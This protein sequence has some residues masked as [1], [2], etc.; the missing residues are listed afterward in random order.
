MRYRC[1]ECGGVVET[2]RVV[3][4]NAR[5]TILDGC[6]GVLHACL[7]VRAASA[8]KTFRR[9]NIESA[10]LLVAGLI[11]QVLKHEKQADEL[12]LPEVS[13]DAHETAVV[14]GQVV[15]ELRAAAEKVK[16]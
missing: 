2:D 1:S 8:K 5:C 15:A 12:G 4:M 7:K 6:T 16:S 11:P 14:L 10:C 3:G 13:L 9:C